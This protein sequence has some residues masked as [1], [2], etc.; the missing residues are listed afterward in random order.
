LCLYGHDIHTE[1][2]P[3]EAALTW[4]IQKVRR[5]G[6]ARA[7]GFPGADAI[8]D[9]LMNGAKRK[10]VGLVGQERAPVREGATLVD[11][12]GQPLGVV[13]SGTLAPTV[14]QVVAMAYLPIA[15]AVVGQTVWAE[16]RGKKLP[17]TVTAMPFTPNRYYRG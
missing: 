16:V 14:N 9:Q 4:A 1:T 12:S 10:R 6:G 5:V 3:V 8:N 13:T 2:T 15:Q 7:G 11:A 17:M